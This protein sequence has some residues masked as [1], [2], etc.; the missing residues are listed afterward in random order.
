MTDE[1]EATKDLIGGLQREIRD[2]AILGDEISQEMLA[3]GDDD[4][5]LT[6]TFQDQNKKHVS[7]DIK[8]TWDEVFKVIGPTIYGYILRKRAG[9]GEKSDFSVSR[10]FG[11][12]HQGENYRSGSKQED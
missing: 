7:E 3:Q 8:L 11:G 2:R 5:E 10:Q 1:L 9:Y 12:A 6:I 4:C